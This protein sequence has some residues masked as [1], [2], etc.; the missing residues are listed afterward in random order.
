[1]ARQ[2]P[3]ARGGRPRDP[4]DPGRSRC[5]RGPRRSSPSS[6]RWRRSDGGQGLAR[7]LRGGARRSRARDERI[8]TVDADLSKSTM[9]AGFAKT[10]PGRAFNVGIAESGMIGWP[11]ASPSRAACP[12]PAR[13]RASWSVAS[14]R[15]ASR[16][17]TPQAP[18]KLVGTHVGVAIGE[19]GY[20]QMG[21]EDIACLRVAAQHPHR[22][23][24]RRD[25]DEAGRRL[26]G[27]ASRPDLSP[28]HPAEPRAGAR[29]GATASVRRVA[30]RS[31]RA[32]T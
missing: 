16:S 18:V 3:E 6:P 14:R 5:P 9:T 13:S 2:G 30:R 31:G 32:A 12:S 10:Y 4:R 29:R 26:R 27:R 19:D 8:V 28:P 20:T 24:R 22:P 15:S 11:P 23:A 25:R 1:M 7:G 17:P 21:L